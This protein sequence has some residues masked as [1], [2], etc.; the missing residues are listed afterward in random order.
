MEKVEQI[1]IVFFTSP[2]KDNAKK[3]AKE[4]IDDKLAACCSLVNDV[5]S[6]FEWDGKVDERNEV[7]IIIKTS[8]S[9]LNDLEK[10]ILK[11]SLDD[12]PEIVSIPVDYAHSEYYNWLI[13]T[14]A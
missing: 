8:E 13:N 10:R 2:S 12:V 5:T 14:V 1:H 3:I 7:M 11:L 9:K 4:L 6:F